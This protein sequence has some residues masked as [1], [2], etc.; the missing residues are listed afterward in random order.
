MSVSPEPENFP[1]KSSNVE[2]KAIKR[3]YF[4]A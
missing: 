4:Y 2:Q 3:G 1:E